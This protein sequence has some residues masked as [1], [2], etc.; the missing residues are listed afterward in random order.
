LGT[1]RT[2]ASDLF[3]AVEVESVPLKFETFRGFAQARSGVVPTLTRHTARGAVSRDARPFARAPLLT[4][5]N[6]RHLLIT[7][8]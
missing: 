6:T 1:T 3:N 5:V 4:T 7:Q 2:A 8:R